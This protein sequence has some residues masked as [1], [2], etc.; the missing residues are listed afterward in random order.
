MIVITVPLSPVIASPALLVS[1]ITPPL[2]SVRPPILTTLGW[3]KSVAPAAAGE[4]EPRKA[5]TVA[6]WLTVGDDVRVA[7]TMTGSDAISG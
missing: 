3:M 4:Y 5:W 7:A 1:V 2:E 6:A